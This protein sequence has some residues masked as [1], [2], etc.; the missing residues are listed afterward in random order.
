[1]WTAALDRCERCGSPRLSITLG[2]VS[3]RA[4]GRLQGTVDL[5]DPVVEHLLEP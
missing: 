1:M 4:C 3:C 5:T 2:E